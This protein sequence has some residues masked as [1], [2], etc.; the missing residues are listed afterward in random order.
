VKTV[1]LSGGFG[2]AAALNW[3]LEHGPARAIGFAYGQPHRD[4]EL[5][6]AGLIAARRS[7]PFDVLLLPDLRPLNPAA[8]RDERG[9]S[10][11]FVPGRNALFLARAAAA[12]AVPGEKL[13]LVMGANAD[14][15]AGFPD[16]RPTFFREMTCALRAALDGVCEVAIETPW[17]DCSKAQI[18]RWALSRPAA[19]ADVRDSVSCYRG[20]RCGECDACSLRARAF[21]EVG[22]EDGVSLTK[23]HGGDPGRDAALRGRP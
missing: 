16:C 13:T 11:A 14:D 18:L 19:L 17:I 12:A 20:T 6:A 3:A 4:A 21:A 10:R 9:V 15:A 2:S 22:P 5:T 8:G 7:V 1:L 23:M